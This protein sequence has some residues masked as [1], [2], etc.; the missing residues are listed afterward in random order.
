MTKRTKEEFLNDFSE[1]K[2]NMKIAKKIFRD[3]YDEEVTQLKDM[4]K[5]F[6]LGLKI[7]DPITKSD[8]SLAIL[9][10]NQRLQRMNNTQHM[11][12][13]MMLGDLEK[14]LENV[15]MVNGIIDIIGDL[16]RDSQL[17]SVQTKV[18]K[19]QNFQNHIINKV[20]Q[21]QKSKPD[22]T[23]AYAGVK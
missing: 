1:L 4:E 8:L 5:V 7:K 16:A 10:V 19:L 15:L 18:T 23:Q 11:L 2:T 6:K 13:H 14:T 17:K 12:I 21:N 9:L 20:K 22:L 3:A